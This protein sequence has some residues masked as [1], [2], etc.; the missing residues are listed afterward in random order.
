MLGSGQSRRGGGEEVN[1]FTIT[2]FCSDGTDVPHRPGYT[3]TLGL[4]F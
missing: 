4:A 2:P 3:V 1:G